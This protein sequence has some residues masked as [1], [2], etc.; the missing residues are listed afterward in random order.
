MVWNEKITEDA[1]RKDLFE[2]LFDTNSVQS[3]ERIPFTRQVPRAVLEA[4]TVPRESRDE[5]IS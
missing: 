4:G 5:P 3:P 2:K 1:N